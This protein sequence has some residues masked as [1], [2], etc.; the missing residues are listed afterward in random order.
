[1]TRNPE[2]REGYAQPAQG[3]IFAGTIKTY[4]TGSHGSFEMDFEGLGSNI[5]GAFSGTWQIKNGTGAYARLHGTGTWYEDDS[6]PGV[7]SFPCIGQVHFD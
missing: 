1:M 7:F 3:Q 5:T 6:T 4:L 2:R